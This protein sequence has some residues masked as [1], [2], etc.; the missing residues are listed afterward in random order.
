[1]WHAADG[2][3]R[4]RMRIPLT[5]DHLSGSNT[6]CNVDLSGLDDFFWDNV[7][8]D[9]Y[10]LRVTDSDG[11]TA[12]VLQRNSFNKVTRVGDLDIKTYTVEAG[13][14][15]QLWLYFNHS[16]SPSDGS[17]TFTPGTQDTAYGVGAIFNRG[18]FVRYRQQRRGASKPRDIVVK[19]SGETTRIIWDFTK[20]LARFREPTNDSLLFEELTYAKFDVLLA[21][22][23]QTALKTEADTRFFHPATV[24][25]TVKAGS[26][27][28][29]YTPSLT[30]GT[31]DGRVLNARCLLKV[32][33]VDET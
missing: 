16:G 3:D 27:G 23:D 29:D 15:I 22:V 6:E 13:S 19:G 9:G 5:V 11:V 17:T 18:N 12:A 26:S 8:A 32:Q 4:W 31:S 25:T 1:M 14:L 33:D 28:T 7:A 24:V 20:A 10:D 30:V 2:S 21:T